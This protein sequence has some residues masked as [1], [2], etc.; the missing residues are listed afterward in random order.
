M[1]DTHTTDRC[2]TFRKYLQNNQ[3]Y[4]WYD[5]TPLEVVA[6]GIV[7][8]SSRSASNNSQRGFKSPPS[9]EHRPAT[10]GGRGGPHGGGRAPEQQPRAFERPKRH[11]EF[12]DSSS[13]QGA[14]P[15]QVRHCH[16]GESR[17]R[18]VEEDDLSR[19]QQSERP[20]E[21][22][23]KQRHGTP[24]DPDHLALHLVNYFLKLVDLS[25]NGEIVVTPARST[26]I[27][28]CETNNT[29]SEL[30]Q[31]PTRTV[32]GYD[33]FVGDFVEKAVGKTT[34]LPRARKKRDR[35]LSHVA[36][37]PRPA[38]SGA[39]LPATVPTKGLNAEAEHFESTDHS[40]EPGSSFDHT[41]LRSEI[42]SDVD[43]EMRPF[44]SCNAL[45][46]PVAFT[47]KRKVET[48]RGKVPLP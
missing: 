6:M 12:N 22:G 34:L 9:S 5:L 3:G 33:P 17:S 28:T 47:N 20:Q 48:L 39:T 14:K 21:K 29:C 16:S 7:S 40:E 37:R 32:V 45:T 46:L 26:A 41:P 1:D 43:R 23:N 31:V 15:G 35:R 18:N 24:K 19:T 25:S 30:Q 2:N 27:G 44:V 10:R 36:K 13:Q 11:L 42:P 4:S 38:L 8:P